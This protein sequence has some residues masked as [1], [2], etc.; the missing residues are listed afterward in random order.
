MMAM[1]RRLREVR[2]SKALSQRDLSE[3][4]GVAQ[5]SIVRLEHGRPARH[6]TTRKL[7]EALGVEPS[8]LVGAPEPSPIRRVESN[9]LIEVPKPDRRPATATGSA[10][11]AAAARQ[12]AERYRLAGDE[13]GAARC[14]AIADEL[15]QREDVE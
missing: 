4:S 10:T 7:A 1:L 6:I 14:E 2:E 15:E 12:Q 13:A 3:R 9:E 8:D 11:A 5:A